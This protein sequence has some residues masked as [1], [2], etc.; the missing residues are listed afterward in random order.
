MLKKNNS[1]L[2]EQLTAIAFFTLVILFILCTHKSTL[3]LA[4]GKK[5][6]TMTCYFYYFFAGLHPTKNFSSKNCQ[7]NNKRVET[8]SIFSEHLLAQGTQESWRTKVERS[9]V[10]SRI[11]IVTQWH[12]D[13]N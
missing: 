10:N 9:F 1:C 13:I 3:Y 7:N 11:D 12:T 4:V 2:I 5:K 8:G 6:K